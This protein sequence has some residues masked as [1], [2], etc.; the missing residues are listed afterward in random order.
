MIKRRFVLG[1]LAAVPLAGCMRGATA[2]PA[3]PRVGGIERLDPRL[4]AI[5]DAD[6][7]VEQLS[8][9]YGWAEGPVWVPGGGYLLFTDPGRNIAYRWTPGVGAAPFLDP[10]GLA[11]AVPAGVREAGANGMR[12][13]AQGR[14]ILA[15]SGT[16][17]I[18]RVDLASRR[19]TVLASA[20]QGKR[21]NSPNDVTLA[22]GG[23]IYFTDPPYGLSEGDESPLRETPVNG[24]Y[25]LAP[26]GRVDLLDGSH[27]RPN[28][29]ALSPDER[30]LYVS[31]SDEARPEVMAYTLDAAGM[32]TGSRTFR[33]MRPQFAAGRPGLPDGMK[34][35]RTGHVFATGPGGV[36][37]CT[38][39]GELLGIIGTGKAV[40]NCAFGGADGRTLFLTSH[41]MLAQ[42]RLK[43]AG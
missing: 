11:G 27:K 18:A 2:A 39:E 12:L 32:P 23:A 42:V 36:H 15:D 41:D 14:L 24:V 19:R 38:P 31:L 35:A 10:S 33:D 3:Y 30:T 1:G 6:A 20:Y 40:A 9:G 37:V 25:R 21:F 13:D 4:D 26:D 28:G 16:R 17:V 34:V 22:R 43:I 7:P 29:I 5:V 8:T